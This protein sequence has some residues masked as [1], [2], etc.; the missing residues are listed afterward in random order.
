MSSN[1]PDEPPTKAENSQDSPAKAEKVDPVAE[2]IG[3]TTTHTLRIQVTKL[4]EVGR[5]D[6]LS[7]THQ[8]EEYLLLCK[9]LWREKGKTTGQCSVVGPMPRTPFNPEMLVYK[10]SPRIVSAALG[11]DIPVEES[12]WIQRGGRSR[13]PTRSKM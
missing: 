3:K 13:L 8:G 10:A 1:P 11:I 5:N 12:V 9:E 2:I 7:I 4:G 6:F